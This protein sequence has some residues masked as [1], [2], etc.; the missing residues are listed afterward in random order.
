MY[1]HVGGQQMVDVRSIVAIIKEHPSKNKKTNPL[2][3]YYRPL[4]AAGKNQDRRTGCYIVTEDCIYAS[5]ITLETMIE[6]Y[7]KIFSVIRK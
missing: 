6:R 4:I 3:Q 1:L 7:K 2:H 5:S